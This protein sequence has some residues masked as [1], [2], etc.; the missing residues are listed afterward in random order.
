MN[1]DPSVKKTPE[2]KTE[3][4]FESTRRYILDTIKKIDWTA[5]GPDTTLGV[6]P[7]VGV[8]SLEGVEE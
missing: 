1:E 2:S 6:W 7:T 5:P 4:L 3:D 8:S